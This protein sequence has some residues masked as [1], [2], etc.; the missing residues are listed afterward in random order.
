MPA[1]EVE[2]AGTVAE[3]DVAMVMEIVEDTERGLVRLNGRLLHGAA[4]E[5]D[6]I[7]I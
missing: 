4:Q 5:A 3:T 1:G 2:H 7:K 6:R